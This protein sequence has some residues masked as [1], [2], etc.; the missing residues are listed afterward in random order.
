[1]NAASAT[2]D[3]SVKEAK[4]FLI[5][6]LVSQRIVTT[7]NLTPTASAVAKGKV[8]R[9]NPFAIVLAVGSLAAYRH[10]QCSYN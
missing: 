1:M 5:R 10:L 6:Y 9:G 8:T 2:G 4:K 3:I 7:N